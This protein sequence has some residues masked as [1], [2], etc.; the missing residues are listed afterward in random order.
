MK[1]TTFE[2][3]VRVADDLNDEWLRIN[4]VNAI[5]QELNECPSLEGEVLGLY[6]KKVEHL[7]E[8]IK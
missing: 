3:I 4:I 8:V 2:L 1:D 6:L 7:G 5:E